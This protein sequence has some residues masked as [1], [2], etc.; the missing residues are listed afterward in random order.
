MRTKFVRTKNVDRFCAGIAAVEE[1]G[2]SEACFLLGL[3]ES[4][5]GKTACGEWW[6]AHNNAVSVR[7]KAAATPNWVLKDIATELGETAPAHSCEGLFKQIIRELGKNPR[8]IVIDEVENAVKGDLAVIETIRDISDLCEIPVILLGR[9]KVA[10][11]L[12]REDQIWSRVSAT[13]EFH[14]AT[15]EDVTLCFEEIC[16]CKVDDSVIAEIHDKCEGRIRDVMT[17]IASI[18][19]IGLR[20][21][22]AAVTTEHTAR[23]RLTPSFPAPAAKAA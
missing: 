3:G 18:E 23:V 16:E 17:A 21:K 6:A 11:R 4:G 15:L 9:K 5:Y 1:R 20:L 19:R 8:P 7:V 10:S 2:A 14:P 12:K 22:G 13:A